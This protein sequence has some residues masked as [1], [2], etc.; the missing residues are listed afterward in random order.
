MKINEMAAPR[1]K[2]GVIPFIVD[3]A[4][5][6]K[7]MFMVPSNPAY[8]GSEYQIAKG[9]VDAGEDIQSAAIREGVEELGLKN[10]NILKVLPGQKFT[11]T[12][13]TELYYLTVIAV[14]VKSSRDFDQPHYETGKVGWLTIND[15]MATGRKSQKSIVQKMFDSIKS[16]N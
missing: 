8:G 9:S 10:E 7:M 12:G 1:N 6:I 3:P 11:L 4:G 5:N 2:A 16:Q 15:F 14:Q 13:F